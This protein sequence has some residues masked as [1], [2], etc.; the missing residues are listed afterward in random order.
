ML[1]EVAPPIGGECAG[2]E[3][4]HLSRDSLFAERNACANA[5]VKCIRFAARFAVS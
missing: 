5:S 1:G 3:V 2:E 4:T